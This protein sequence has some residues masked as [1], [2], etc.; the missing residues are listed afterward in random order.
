MK[1]LTGDSQQSKPIEESNSRH[2]KLTDTRYFGKDKSD[3]SLSNQQYN[4]C[5]IYLKG[6]S[7]IIAETWW[8]Q[9]DMIMYKTKLGIL[10]IEKNTVEK[11]INK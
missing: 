2:R 4:Y 3:S 10:G 6:G 9:G 1:K 8:E 5:E 11:I 7:V